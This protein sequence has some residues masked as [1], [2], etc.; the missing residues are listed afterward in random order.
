[1]NLPETDTSH[2]HKQK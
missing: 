1:L 2:L